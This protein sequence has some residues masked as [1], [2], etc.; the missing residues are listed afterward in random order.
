MRR[1]RHEGGRPASRHRGLTILM[2]G[3]AAAIGGALPSA[4][5][6]AGASYVSMGD[7][8]TAGPGIEPA[9]PTAPPECGQSTANYPHLVAAALGLSLTDVSCSGAATGDFTEAQ[10][11]DQPPQFDALSSS[12]EVVTIGM[13]GNDHDLFGTL[14]EGCTRRD[15]F[16]GN[17]GAPCKKEFSK[18][19][20]QVQEEDL[21]PAEQALRE[22]HA[23]S[24]K[25]TVFIVG[26]PEITPVEGY[27]PTAIPWTSG[28][29]K[30][31][32]SV[33]VHGNAE[34]KKEAK[35]NDA[36]FVNTFGP[37]AGHDLCEPV[38]VRWIEPLLDPL[39]GVP[40]H[41]NAAGQ[42]NDAWDVEEAMLTH[43]VR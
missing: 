40:V 29:L 5:S 43:G 9:S 31:F 11:P 21:G 41:P 14:V 27:C 20:K 38:G 37:S 30:W 7:S 8:Y 10:Y 26:Y 23:L 3:V 25:A 4:A 12:T 34:L 1:V 13:G 39:T 24:P 35:A 17:N 28:D 2:I 16:A 36:V 18:F 42:E 32:H 19:V 33:E 15:Y 22:V 6:A